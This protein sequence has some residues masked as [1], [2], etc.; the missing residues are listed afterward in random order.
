[1]LVRSRVRRLRF[2]VRISGGASTSVG[3]SIIVKAEAH[4]D[5]ALKASSSHTATSA[6]Q[7]TDKIANKTGHN[8]T[9]GFYSGV[10][11]AYGGWKFSYCK[12]KYNSSGDCLGT[13][14]FWRYGH[15]TSY[16]F[17]D[18]GAVRCGAGTKY[19]SAVAKQ[20]P[21]RVCG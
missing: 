12:G 17:S 1:M 4:L 14:L 21:R 16:Q 8:A 18:S 3:N 5:M 19:I 15:W 9:Y 11:K 13:Y 6:I 10:T 20:A 7:V 2:R